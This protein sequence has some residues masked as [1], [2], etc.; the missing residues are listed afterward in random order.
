LLALAAGAAMVL[1]VSVLFGL[2]APPGPPSS[3]MMSRTSPHLLDLITALASGAVCAYAVTT[4]RLSA[5]IFGVSIAVALVPP[6]ATAGLFIARDDWELAG[7]EWTGG[8][9]A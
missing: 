1:G 6:L 4:P 3:E 7:G 8:R 2:L 5:A 9:V